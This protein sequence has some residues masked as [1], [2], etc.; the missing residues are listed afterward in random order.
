MRPMPNHIRVF[1]KVGVAY[2]YVIDNAY[3]VDL[4]AGVEFMLSAI[5]YTNEDG[6]FND[7]KYEY[8]TIALPFMTTRILL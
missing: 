8:E 3:I 5:I 6:I 1:N 4:E 7:D 2:G